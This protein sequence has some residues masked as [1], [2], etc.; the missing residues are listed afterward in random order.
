MGRQYVNLLEAYNSKLLLT[1][2][3]VNDNIDLEQH[4]CCKTF[5]FNK[6]KKG[7]GFRCVFRKNEDGLDNVECSSQR[8]SIEKIKAKKIYFVGF[9]HWGYYKE[10]FCL[11]CADG[12][13]VKALVSFSDTSYLCSELGK[14]SLGVDKEYYDRYSKIFCTLN[15]KFGKR[16]MYYTEI[17]IEE[18]EI[19]EII[20][21]DNCFMHIFAITIEY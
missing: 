17:E 4:V 9:C 19:T 7:G 5:S 11:R 15:T 16:Y 10:T 20:F 3:E 21:P 12:S 14:R 2:P 6:E 8:I 1:K 13:V 18:K